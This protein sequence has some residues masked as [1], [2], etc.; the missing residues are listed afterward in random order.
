MARNETVI[1]VPPERVFAVLADGRSYGHWV[2]GS[3]EIRA[4]D[5]GFPAVGTAFHHKVG[6]GPL[7]VADHTTV[8]EVDA[9][10]LLKLRAKARPLG[11]ATV[12]MEL[13]PHPQGTRVVMIEDAGDKLTQLVFNPLTH[14]M[15]RGRNVESLRR[16]KAMAEG[17]G[18]SMDQAAAP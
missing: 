12:V 11:T 6:F 4:V 8:L 14:L 15:V 1:A 9:P 7:K 10:R 2:V 17:H 5:D 13:H 3:S 18:P 16:L